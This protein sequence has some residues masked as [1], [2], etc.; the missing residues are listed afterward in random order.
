MIKMIINKQII[1]EDLI[2][3][4]EIG[5]GRVN[6][7]S[8]SKIRKISEIIKY[9]ILKGINNVFLLSNP[10]SND[11]FIIWFSFSIEEIIFHVIN[12]NIVRNKVIIR[13]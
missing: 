2:N 3:S 13:T 10:D 5:V 6:T 1:I 12:N 11:E 9:C 8:K 4:L 7:I